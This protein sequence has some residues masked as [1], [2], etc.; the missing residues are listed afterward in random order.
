MEA[1][2]DPHAIE[3]SLYRE[4]EAANY[5]A[6]RDG[7]GYCI[8]I[9]PPNVT[10]S[11]HMG[12]AFQHTLMDA[13]IR[14][15]RM[16]GR[17]ALWQM[18]TD[19]AGIST[20][21]LVERQL[22]AEGKTRAGLGREKFIKRVWQWKRESGGNISQQLRR[23][24]SSLDWTRE[25]FTLDEGYA[26]A[27]VEA[28]VRL[29]EDGLIYRGQRLVNWDPTLGTAI[30]DLEVIN[31]EE[32]GSLWRLRYPLCD[33]VKTPAGED[34]LVVATTRPETMLGDTAVAVH[35]EDE[36]YQAL[37]GK[38]VRL[39][40]VGR[41]LPIIADRYVDPA[42][43]SGCVK[44]TPAHDFNDNAVA[45]RHGLP[46][47]N[48][49]TKAAAVND[50]A[51]A[52]YQ[53]LDRFAARQR[54]VDDLQALGLLDEV[55]P[56]KLMAP[57]GDRSGAVI[58]PRLTHQWFVKIA[59]LAAPAVQAVRDGRIE[60]VPKGYE[61]TYFAWMRNIQDW[62]ISRQQWWGHRIP[63]WYGPDGAIYVGRNEADARRREGLGA[64]LPLRQ[65]EDVLETW[66]SSSLWTFATLGWPERTADLKRFHPTDVLVTG[67]DIIFFW[68]ARMIMMA[69]RLTGEIPFRQVYIHGLVRDAAG[70]KMSKTK[71]NGL[72]PLDLIDGIDLEG[73][74]AKRT[75]NLT[76]PHLAP[77]IAKAT[78]RE[79]P[80]GIPSYGT[81]ALRFTFCALA[82]T[83]RDVRFD[84]SRTEGYRN[85]CNKLWNA[86]RFVL[87]NVQNQN[88]SEATS[89]RRRSES[90]VRMGCQDRQITATQDANKQ[91][92][93]GSATQLVVQDPDAAAS[94]GD[95][96]RP[97]AGDAAQMNVKD[98]QAAARQPL[99]LADRW[100]LSRA[101]QMVAAANEALET[102]R[103]DLCAN[104]IYD[105]AW[106]EYCDWYLELAKPVLWDDSTPPAQ[107]RAVQHTLLRVLDVLLRTTHPVMPFITEAVWCEAAPLLGAQGPSIMLQPYPL[108][109]ELPADPEADAAIGWLKSV[110]T[111]LR[112]IRGEAGIKP[113]QEVQVLLQGGN[114]RDR[115]LAAHTD[116]LV[117]RLAKVEA[118][119]WLS[120]ETQPPPSALSLVGDLKVLVPLAGL[121][122][123]KAE[124]VRLDKAL[125]RKRT[126]LERLRRKLNNQKFI[127]NA[128][129]E[130]V[131]RERSKAA[132]AQSRLD[133][134]AA[135]MESLG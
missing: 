120:A 69:L 11:L 77:A 24:G 60:F 48:V 62:C 71:G 111:A 95:Y 27:V 38:R 63:A 133:A 109:E 130:L 134:L 65:E 96:G 33:G 41:E 59:P 1:S 23:M 118:I 81:D 58:E 54:I 46:L 28:F 126:E 73:L 79:F 83:G 122:D 78:K 53:G 47:I 110:V 101:R 90:R 43:G 74:L 2:F 14:F 68:V 25:R 86:A 10:G 103:F 12:H 102:Y 87:M 125:Q 31:A 80:N 40:L 121:I 49:L 26:R 19:H 32:E 76:Q 84:L 89:K 22:N 123:L 67:H 45:A 21:M 107:R 129:S 39:P 94:D 98:L 127:D 112:N 20:Q 91:P 6:P 66:F 34:H 9:P 4:W 30:S 15:Q 92:E 135:Q 61:N 99:G 8:Q 93:A 128:P 114:V 131:Q 7:D 97:Q 115:E 105:F 72:D 124:R 117:R 116:A 37:I 104:Q 16:R 17:G 113:G 13:L 50:N 85:F 51:P 36:R 70:R 35:P 3:R 108:V 132:E 57:R 119:Q 18:G 56:H 44:I 42:F 88:P 82:S 75:A 55:Q 106:H 52:A 64:D 5:F 29:H 100:I